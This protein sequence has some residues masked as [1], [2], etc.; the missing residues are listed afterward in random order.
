MKQAI[1]ALMYGASLP[2]VSKKFNIP[3]H[4]LKK[5]VVGYCKT[6]NPEQCEGI[7]DD[8]IEAFDW[9]QPKRRFFTPNKKG[10]LYEEPKFKIAPREENPEEESG[11]TEDEEDEEDDDDQV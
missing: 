10:E 11:E 7:P 2:M 6:I 5:Q 8:P 9:L 4:E 3:M 1:I